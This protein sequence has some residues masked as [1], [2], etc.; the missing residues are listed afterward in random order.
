LLLAGLQSQTVRLERVLIVDS[1]STDGTAQMAAAAGFDVISIT[2]AE[3]NHGR[4]RQM[5]AE[6]IPDAEILVYMTQD[7]QL[8]EPDSITRL[9]EPFID[10]TV[11]AAY[12]RQVPRADA[13]PIEAHARHFNYPERSQVKSWE[14]R[15][16]LGIRATFLSNSFSAYRR[17]A[18]F[19]V[20]GFPANTIMAEDAL[21]AGK[22][23]MAQWKIAYV[24]EATALHSHP[25]S[26]ADEF[27][28]YFDTGVYHS[29][30]AWL[31]EQFG[32][33]SGEGKRF[34][35][36]ELKA[37]WPRH[38]HLIPASGARTLAK[39]VGYNLGLREAKLPPKLRR[40]LSLHKRFWDPPN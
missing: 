15:S 1:S 13:G 39:L 23:L 29:H 36:S 6:S 7:A 24:A 10:P 37:L 11:G 16:T 27:K 17:S 30:E 8:M 34:V 26:V 35:F 25:Y 28:R 32:K 19:A 18:L 40:R 9:I 20:G 21:V 2:R 38:L 5:A 31:L 33:A 22:M 3:F 12:G 14:D 4:T